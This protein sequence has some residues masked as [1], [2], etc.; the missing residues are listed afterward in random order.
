MWLTGILLT[1]FASAAAIGATAWMGVTRSGEPIALSLLGGSAA[2]AAVGV[3]LW[4]L[5]GRSPRRT[6]ALELAP[7]RV[8]IVF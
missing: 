6:I 2:L 8:R 1:T 5:G 7:R 3:P 4:V